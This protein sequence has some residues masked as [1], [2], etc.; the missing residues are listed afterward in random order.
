MSGG[1][2]EGWSFIREVVV[3]QR[4]VCSGEEVGGQQRRGHSSVAWSFLR[5]IVIHWRVGRSFEGKV[6]HLRGSHLSK[7]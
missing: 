7:G 1:S 4:G 2:V 6:V 3:L 5:G